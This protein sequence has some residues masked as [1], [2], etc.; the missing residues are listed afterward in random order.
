MRGKAMV[1][2][3]LVMRLDVSNLDPVKKIFV[4]VAE[5]LD[6]I[7]EAKEF[8]P[9]SVTTLTSELRRTFESFMFDIQKTDIHLSEDKELQ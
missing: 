8:C 5:L 6:Q 9:L 2:Q 3:E 1:Q 4:L 7:E